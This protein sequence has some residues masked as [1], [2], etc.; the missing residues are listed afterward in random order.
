MTKDIFFK[1]PSN[2]NK[3]FIPPEE[4]GTCLYGFSGSLFSLPVR[5]GPFRVPLL[6]KL[7][8]MWTAGSLSGLR[9]RRCK[10]SCDPPKFSKVSCNV[11]TIM[12]SEKCNYCKVTPNRVATCLGCKEILY[13]FI[14]MQSA[15]PPPKS[16]GDKHVYRSTTNFEILIGF[17]GNWVCTQKHNK[18]Y[19]WFLWNWVPAGSA[20]RVRAPPLVFPVARPASGETHTNASVSLA[21]GAPVSVP[22]PGRGSRLISC[23]RAQSGNATPTMNNEG[24]VT[25]AKEQVMVKHF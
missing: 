3:C 10:F 17:V 13:T 23:H 1:K 12:Q 4:L 5:E 22:R 14:A 24:L 6:L 18:T 9:P 20:A 15:N 19:L 16:N 8:P 21:F 7:R 2:S 25:S 11:H